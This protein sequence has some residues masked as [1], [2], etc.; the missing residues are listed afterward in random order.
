MTLNGWTGA[1]G[2]R[3]RCP[4]VL[5]GYRSSLDWWLVPLAKALRRVNPDVFTWLSLL[6]AILG[7]LAFWRSGPREEPGLLLAA[8][9]CVLLNSVFDLLDGKIAKMTGKAT[10]RGDYLDHCVDRFSDAALLSGIAFSP[11][12][13]LEWGL[14][15]IVGT[16]LTSYMGTQ[17]QAVGLRRNYAGLLGRADRMVLLLVVP[18]V[19]YAWLEFIPGVDY[20]PSRLRWEGTESW[21]GLL[22][23]YFAVV[24]TLT[25]AQRFLS[26][27]RAFGKDGQ[28]KE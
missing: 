20:L 23:I 16:L 9:A 22:V 26:G 1:T 4:L 7:G 8:W 12:A 19:E 25:T 6:F 17:A 28:I 5:D 14:L 15:A 2:S 21:L 10:P 27:L 18:L 24:G 3:C 11:W 13:S